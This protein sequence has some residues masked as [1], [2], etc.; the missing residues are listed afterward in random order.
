MF[1]DDFDVVKS[2][3]P[4]ESEEEKKDMINLVSVHPQNP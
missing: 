2:S 3:K 4:S 1:G